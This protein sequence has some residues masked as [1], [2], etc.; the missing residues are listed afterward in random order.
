MISLIFEKC[1]LISPATNKEFSQGE[2]INF[3]TTDVGLL[4]WL[5]SQIGDRI[6]LP[7][8]FLSVVVL[9]YYY[10]GSP[11]TVVVVLLVVVMYFE[12]KLANRAASERKKHIDIRDKRMNQTTEIINNI[13]SIKLNSWTE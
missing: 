1:L 12:A 3:I 4:R 8:Q 7:I 6:R 11:F 5:T 9:M 13:K 2:I 10:I